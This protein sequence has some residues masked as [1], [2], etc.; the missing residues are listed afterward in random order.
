MPI[1]RQT[2]VEHKGYGFCCAEVHLDIPGPGLAQAIRQKCLKQKLY[3][4]LYVA[5]PWITEERERHCLD[6]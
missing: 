3:S 6:C 2:V 1:E 4:I 5:D